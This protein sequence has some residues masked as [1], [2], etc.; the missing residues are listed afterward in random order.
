[1]VGARGRCR[2]CDE[3]LVPGAT[4]C[5]HCGARVE[6]AADYAAMTGRVVED[7]VLSV[8]YGLV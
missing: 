2:V 4:F 6:D 3:P 1:M 5:P 8:K 7:F